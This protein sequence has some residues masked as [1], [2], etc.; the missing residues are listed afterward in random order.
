MKGNQ[1]AAYFKK[2]VE[3]LKATIPIVT[4]LR[5]EAL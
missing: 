4:Y 3:N 1:M 2:V 5:D